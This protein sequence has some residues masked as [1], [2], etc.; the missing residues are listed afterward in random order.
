MK[1]A[2]SQLFEYC[3]CPMAHRSSSSLSTSSKFPIPNRNIDDSIHIYMSTFFL[4]KLEFLH[5]FYYF[6]ISSI[7]LPISNAFWWNYDFYKM[8]RIKFKYL[9]WAIPPI[10]QISNLQPKM[11]IFYNFYFI[12]IFTFIQTS[13]WHYPKKYWP[14]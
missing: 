1:A 10:Q 6:S 11:A 8:L 7:K 3:F 12:H 9:P 13:H 4:E 5:V 2:G 14:I